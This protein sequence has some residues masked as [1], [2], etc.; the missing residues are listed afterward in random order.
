[1]TKK[2]YNLP[3]MVG[4]F[5]VLLSGV[6]LLTS[7]QKGDN[8]NILTAAGLKEPFQQLVEKYKKEHPEVSL[9]VVYSGSGSL[10]VKLEKNYGDIY[11]PAAVSYIETAERKNLVDAK[12]V[13]IIAY[14]EPVLVVREDLKVNSIYDLAR[15]NLKFG[16]SD[17]REAAIGKITYEILKKV[18]LWVELSKKAVVRT[19]TV[20]QLVLYLKEGQLDAAIIWKELA[21]KLKGFKIIEFPDRLKK[22]EPIP[23]GV[24]TFSQSRKSALE[25]EEFILRYREL[26]EKYGFLVEEKRPK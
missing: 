2:T 22:V 19:P 9:N 5:L 18:G 20:N 7:C 12:T 23:V 16:I 6:F 1:M 13:K 15:L 11:I 8:L 3:K 26:F 10:L 14:H 25:F 4:R 24:S 17:P 21:L